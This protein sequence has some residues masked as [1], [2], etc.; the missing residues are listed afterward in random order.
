MSI[1][2]SGSERQVR[3]GSENVSR[4]QDKF[5]RRSK[6]GGETFR[7]GTAFQKELGIVEKL[8]LRAGK[9]GKTMWRWGIGNPA[10]QQDRVSYKVRGGKLTV[11]DDD[12]RT[13][14]ES[15]EKGLSKYNGMTLHGK[16]NRTGE[17][18]VKENWWSRRKLEQGNVSL[19]PNER[20]ER[21][22]AQS[23]RLLARIL[24]P[25]RKGKKERIGDN[26]FIDKAARTG[27]RIDQWQQRRS[28]K[29]RHRL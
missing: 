7:E 1:N 27:H 12:G 29:R 17:I 24:S 9:T 13:I 3:A 20:K 4:F 26:W 23:A 6:D 22:Q 15:Q 5:L 28:Q 16:G 8:R 25:F 19:T 21:E 11:T 10:K 2:D 14:K 18:E